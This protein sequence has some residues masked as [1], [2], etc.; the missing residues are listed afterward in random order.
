MPR[1][2][3]RAVLILSAVMGAASGPLRAEGASTVHLLLIADDQDKRIGDSVQVS[4]D[5]M[6]ETFITNLPPGRLKLETLNGAD[7]GPDAILKAIGKLAVKPKEDVVVVYSATHGGFDP[8]KGAYL[9]FPRTRA[10]LLR[11]DLKAAIEA[12]GAR[13]G[14]LITESCNNVK[15]LDVRPAPGA[16]QAP[17]PPD[18]PS[19]LF[20]ALLLSHV[21]FVDVASS[22]PGERS[23]CY[24]K[25]RA[26][27][28]GFAVGRGGF[29]A[30]RGAIF[31]EALVAAMSLYRDSTLTWAQ[32]AD[33]LGPV[34]RAEFQRVAPEGLEDED[35]PDKVQR[36]QTVDLRS[37]GQWA[38]DPANR[39]KLRLGAIGQGITG[40]GVKVTQVYAGSAAQRIGLEVG[41]VIRAINGVGVDRTDEYTRLVRESGEDIALDVLDWRTGNVVRL[42]GK[43]DGGNGAPPAPAARPRFGAVAQ[44]HNGGAGLMVTH[45]VPGSAAQRIGLEYGDIILTINGR[46]INTQE[47]YI[48][49]MRDSTREMVLTVRNVRT[50]QPQ[51]TRVTLDR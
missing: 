42:S 16:P 34:V 23:L 51:T 44:A 41:D 40:Q 5:R 39:P 11:S 14:V 49:A 37:A 36:T 31:T 7:L 24:P 28:G 3:I 22:R 43:L 50:G 38:P 12:K 10:H 8:Q 19:P 35:E 13:L 30:L 2:A 27:Q 6:M 29:V 25:V 1:A 9:V 33:L 18:E 17:G 4:R 45:L 15:E 46:A 32:M 20:R 21:G 47:D 48:A 26:P